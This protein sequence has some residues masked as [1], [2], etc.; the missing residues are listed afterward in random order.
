MNFSDLDIKKLI[1]IWE[2]C[3]A[4]PTLKGSIEKEF[5][6][7]KGNK[8]Y[9]VEYLYSIN[10]IGGRP[11]VIYFIPQTDCYNKYGK[12][13]VVDLELSEVEANEIYRTYKSTPPV[14]TY[15]ALRAKTWNNDMSVKLKIE[16]SEIGFKTSSVG[17][18]EYE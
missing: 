6:R 11:L 15:G 1:V 12:S 14:R 17:L 16:L 10:K 2:C 4:N 9:S 18:V 8:K 5:E 13:I 7:R 3:N